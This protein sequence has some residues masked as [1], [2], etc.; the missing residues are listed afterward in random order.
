MARIGALNAVSPDGVNYSLNFNE[1]SML[2][3]KN[4]PAKELFVPGQ[5]AKAIR[6][7]ICAPGRMKNLISSGAY[8]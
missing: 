8:T 1:V 2:R 4:Q 7:K 3:K 5:A 6:F